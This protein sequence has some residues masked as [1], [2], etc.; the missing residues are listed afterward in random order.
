ML[1]M[2]EENGWEILNGNMEGDE[3]GE[4]TFIGGKGNSV[5][6]Y[7]IVD[8]AM[9]EDIESFKIEER[10]E[11]DHLPMKVE[12]YGKVRREKPKEEQRKEK[13]LWTEEG[14]RY[15]Q[16]EI[17]KIQLEKEEPNELME[18]LTTEIKGAT[19]KK[20]IRMESRKIGWKN[21]WN[22]EC[23]ER[24]REAKKALRKWK[25]GRGDKEAY[26]VKRREYKKTCEIKR[27]KQQENI[28]EEI[29]QLKKK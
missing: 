12:I 6:D 16:E 1:E 20:V 4:F 24:K 29:E 11:S 15:Y 10:V 23:T 13:N 8:T 26:N 17:E 7:V 22:K 25:Q 21:W 3:A 9:K 5:V 19:R 14:K 18:E 27:E 28:E 2:I